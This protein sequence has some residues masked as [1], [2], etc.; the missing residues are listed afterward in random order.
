VTEV[1]DHVTLEGALDEAADDID[2]PGRNLDIAPA[3]DGQHRHG[4][5]GQDRDRV[6]GQ[7]IA[8]PACRRREGREQ[9][10]SHGDGEARDA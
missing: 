8:E 10:G 1:T 3:G 5:L 9:C 2:V 6:V 4:D 7:E